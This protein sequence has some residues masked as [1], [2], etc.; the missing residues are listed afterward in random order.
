MKKGDKI[1]EETRAKMQIAAKLR[2]NKYLYK[3]DEW[4]KNMS[5]AHLGL[6]FTDEHKENMKKAWEKRK[7]KG[8]VSAETRKKMSESQKR[9]K[10]QQ[11][12]NKE[13][14]TSAN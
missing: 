1:S 5:E 6:V 3:Q 11:K 10:E 8:P 2:W 9:Y 14:G 12:K 13:N 7:L 4:R